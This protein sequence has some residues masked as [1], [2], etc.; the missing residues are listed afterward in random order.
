M[1]HRYRLTHDPVRCR[2]A[3]DLSDGKAVIDYEPRDERTVMLVHTGVPPRHEG[4]GI[5]S[6]LTEA[7]LTD[8]EARGMKVVP[9]CRFIAS[10][11]RRHPRWE[12]ILAEK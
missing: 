6:E 5:A 9:C 7:V 10:Y 4:Q 3:F 11:I 2:Y 12:R 8:L 1:Q